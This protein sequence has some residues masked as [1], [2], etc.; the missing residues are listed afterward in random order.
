MSSWGLCSH[1]HRS[2]ST[3]SRISCDSPSCRRSSFAFFQKRRFRLC[4]VE[5]DLSL[6][7]V[8]TR[9]LL[10]C[11]DLQPVCRSSHP[12]PGLDLFKHTGIRSTHHSLLGID[13]VVG[14]VL[15][16]REGHAAAS[17]GN[18]VSHFYPQEESPM[19]TH[20]SVRNPPGSMPL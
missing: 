13:V 8:H 18:N 15:L 3:T 14:R 5:V 1:P 10:P 19:Q 16:F 17:P 4:N 20:Q 9:P 2:S 11:E 12:I 6:S 7:P